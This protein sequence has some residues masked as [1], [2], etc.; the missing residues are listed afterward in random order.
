MITAII[1]DDELN[2][3]EFL[4]KLIARYFSK[5]IGIVETCDSVK[6][7]VEAIKLHQPDLVFLDIQMPQEKGF[8]LFKYFNP[9]KFEV[10]FTTAYDKYAIEAIRL[11]AI[12]YLLKPI[13]YVD[14]LSSINRLEKRKKQVNQQA[15]FEL[16]L[17]NMDTSNNV[18]NKVALPTQNGFELIKLN[19]IIYCK[20]DGNYCR[21]ICTNEKEF[22]I[23]KTLKFVEELIEN[24]LFIRIH[25]TFLVNLNYVVK[26]DKVD[27]LKVTLTNG[28]Q[29]PV[30]VRKKEH[31]LNAILHK[32]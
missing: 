10:I 20:S 13:N 16:L 17:E 28:E 32:N 24:D 31:F 6:A 4:G 11:S 23:S 12:D 21:V 3:R 7:G 9:I 25:K 2:A 8:E 27:E 29:L 19:S 26:F 15:K 22:L 30:S 5:K 14:L 18:F 1:I